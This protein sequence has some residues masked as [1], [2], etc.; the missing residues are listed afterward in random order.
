M[1]DGKQLS[2]GRIFGRQFS[3]LV[4]RLVLGE[5]CEEETGEENAQDIAA[6]FQWD[7]KTCAWL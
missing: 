1:H 5:L 6:A 4:S 7:V 3:L 2:V